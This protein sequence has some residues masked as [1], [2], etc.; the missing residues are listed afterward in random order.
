MA[1]MVA[2]FLCSS[3]FANTDSELPPLHTHT[4]I[5]LKLWRLKRPHAVGE[6][7]SPPG[8][9]SATTPRYATTTPRPRRGGCERGSANSCR[10]PRTPPWPC[11]M[12]CHWR[13]DS[14]CSPEG[15][16]LPGRGGERRLYRQQSGDRGS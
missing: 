15:S 7:E 1:S 12:R 8:Q 11:R 4:P 16:P 6:G 14:P 13:C 5:D 9:H 2:L 10:S 3:K